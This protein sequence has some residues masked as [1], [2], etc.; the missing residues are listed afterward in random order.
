MKNHTQMSDVEFSNY[1]M[2]MIHCSRSSLSPEN[3]SKT[4]SNSRTVTR[5]CPRSISSSTN[6]ETNSKSSCERVDD[7]FEPKRK[8]IRTD[9]NFSKSDKQNFD[10]ERRS[11]RIA[12]EYL[13]D[14]KLNHDCRRD[15]E[16]KRRRSMLNDERK[17]TDSK[18]VTSRSTKTRVESSHNRHSRQTERR[19]N[20]ENIR[21]PI[22][23]ERSNHHS[24]KSPEIQRVRSSN[25]DDSYLLPRYDLSP[26]RADISSSSIS[27]H[28][29]LSSNSGRH[30]RIDYHH[31]SVNEQSSSNHSSSIRS[32]FSPFDDDFPRSSSSREQKYFDEFSLF[33]SKIF[34]FLFKKFLHLF[35]ISGFQ[36]S[37]FD[38]ETRLKTFGNF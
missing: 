36:T 18:E 3:S 23:N 26:S 34:F 32:T 19:R 7:T 13:S 27:S 9:S 33:D 17:P 1:K 35:R 6:I 38:R 30:K 25:L 4:F 12:G 2:K 10:E 5:I 28:R 31:R 11:V 20:E 21:S 15:L 22:R 8:R 16:E 29:S 24:R 37:K 14:S